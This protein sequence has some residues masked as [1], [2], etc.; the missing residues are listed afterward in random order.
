MSAG[1]RSGGISGEKATVETMYFGRPSGSVLITSSAR[2]VPIVP[3]RAMTP[4]HLRSATSPEAMTAAPRPMAS[5]AAASS[6][7]A[8]SAAMVVPAVATTACLP[9]STGAAVSP[10]TDT[11]SAMTAPPAPRSCRG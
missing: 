8:T 5:I 3:P 10:R 2:S 6:S 4:W 9:I 11:S 1:S 7:A